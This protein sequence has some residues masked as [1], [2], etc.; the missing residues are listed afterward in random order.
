MGAVC[1][2]EVINVDKSYILRNQITQTGIFLSL[3]VAMFV[4]GHFN[5][6]KDYV[7]YLLRIVLAI[8]ESMIYCVSIFV[9]IAAILFTVK[10]LFKVDFQIQNTTLSF[11]I[12]IF[13]MLNSTIILAKFPLKYVEENLKIKWLYP[14][15]LLFTRIISPLFL[16]YGFI[17]ICYIIKVVV[18]KTIPK[19]IITNLILWY[20]LLSV[21]LVFVTKI[22]D[23]KFIRVYR[24]IQPAILLILSVM[25]FYSIGIRISY[26]GITEDRYFVIIA[27]IFIVISMIYYLLFDKKTYMTIPVVFII[28]TIISSVGPLSAY[29]V[30]RIDQKRILDNILI[31]ENLLVDNKI[32]AQTDVNPARIKEIRDKLIYFEQKHRLKELPYISDKFSVCPE[33]M[34][35]VFGFR[36][37][38]FESLYGENRSYTNDSTE[39]F[40]KGYDKIIADIN[41]EYDANSKEISDTSNEN[42][43]FSQKSNDIVI[44]YKNKKIGKFNAEEFKNK[45]EELWDK[46]GPDLHVQYSDLDTNLLIEKTGVIE[47]RKYKIILNHATSFYEHGQKINFSIKCMYTE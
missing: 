10:E 13:L 12:I 31:E 36:G 46:K 6:Q 33:S 39:I 1:F 14:F 44:Q 42:I 3:F 28:L 22:N 43:T 8:I 45:L 21:G 47:K 25:M 35:Q 41:I 26:Y 16:V 17:L 15:K 18:F 32:V 30:S 37:D 5:K 7:H 23:D 27:G 40:V 24:K 34:T 4:A 29:N 20:G 2:F 38:E 19:N 9:G 11:A